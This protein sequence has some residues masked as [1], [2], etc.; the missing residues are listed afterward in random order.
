[1]PKSISP[2][3]QAVVLDTGLTIPIT[4][5]TLHQCF[6]INIIINHI[7]KFESCFWSFCECKSSIDTLLAPFWSLPT[8]EGAAMLPAAKLVLSWMYRS[9]LSTQRQS[10]S[11]HHSSL[12]RDVSGT[13]NKSLFDW[14]KNNVISIPSCWL[15]NISEK[16][17]IKSYTKLV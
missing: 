5:S 8:P 2:L 9:S 17:W 12:L 6:I 10:C 14:P 3:S 16:I 11:W 15:N 7:Q 4:T 1:M 13:I